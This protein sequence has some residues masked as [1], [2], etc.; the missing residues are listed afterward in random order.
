MRVAHMVTARPIRRG[1]VLSTPVPV[2]NG[3][4]VGPHD[5]ELFPDLLPIGVAAR[6]FAAGDTVVYDCMGNTADVIIKNSGH[7]AMVYA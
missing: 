3:A 7:V 2:R 1:T 4:I 5:P 6:D